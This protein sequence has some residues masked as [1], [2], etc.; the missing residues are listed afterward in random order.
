[1]IDGAL[2]TYDH[3]FGD[4]VNNFIKIVSFI[5]IEYEVAKIRKVVVFKKHIE[6]VF[7]NFKNVTFFNEALERD[8]NNAVDEIEESL[9]INFSKHD[10][11][12]F[13][14]NLIL[15][16]NDIQNLL[17]NDS[18]TGYKHKN[19][20]ISSVE[21]LKND[22]IEESYCQAHYSI[23]KMYLDKMQSYLS[24]QREIQGMMKDSEIT[25]HKKNIPEEDE[26]TKAS[27][28]KFFQHLI[29][30]VL[31]RFVDIKFNY[32]SLFFNIS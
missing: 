12:N 1:M 26:S 8:Y 21:K 7:N 19:F 11:L 20:K 24:N 29:F 32:F 14:N 5:N 22:K 17:I 6:I 31:H 25:L 30:V 2:S 28:L 15:K 10:R 3:R 4:N 23:I 18:K 27:P 9:L 13:I 16:F